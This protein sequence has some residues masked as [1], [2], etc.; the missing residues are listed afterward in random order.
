[1]NIAA[2]LYREEEEEEEEEKF[3]KKNNKKQKSIKKEKKKTV[4]SR[5]DRKYMLTPPQEK[6]P[7]TNG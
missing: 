5:F 7:Q 2:R 1:M 4:D 3:R 6:Q